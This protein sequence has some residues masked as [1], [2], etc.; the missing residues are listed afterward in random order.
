MHPT[1]IAYGNLALAIICEVG[2]S[3]LLQRSDWFTKLVPAA[4]TGLCYRVS[5]YLLSVALKDIQLGVAYP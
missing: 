1:L 2:G 4:A 5:F 3:A